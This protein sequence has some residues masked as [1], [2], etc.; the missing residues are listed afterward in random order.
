MIRGISEDILRRVYDFSDMTDEELRCKFFQKLQECIELCNNSSDILEWLK[1]EGLEKGVKDLLTIWLEDGTLE[2]LINIDKLNKKVDTETFNNAITTINEQLDNITQNGE[3]NYTN[4]GKAF[5][6]ES[7]HASWT[8]SNTHFSKEENKV[9]IFY[10]E[11]PTHNVINCKL[12]MVK[13]NSD[14]SFT[15]PVVVVD[16]NPVGISCRS[17]A[18]AILNDGTYF[19]IVSHILN[20]GDGVLSYN[21][22]IYKSSDYGTTWNVKEFLLDGQSVTTYLGDFNGVLV[23]KNGRIITH[24]SDANRGCN[25]LY[26]DDNGNTWNRATWLGNPTKH[27]EPAWCELSDGTLVAYFRSEVGDVVPYEVPAIFTKST[28]G[29][30]TWSAPVNSKS[31]IDYTQCNGNMVYCEESKSVEFLHHSRCA[32]DDGYTSLYVA[33]ANEDDV[34]NDN[35]GNQIRIGRINYCGFIK[36]L[37]VWGDG[38]YVGACRDNDGNIIGTYYNGNKNKASICYFIGKRN[39]VGYRNY[40]IDDRTG[41]KVKKE[42][43]FLYSKG[44]EYEEITGGWENGIN[45]RYGSVHKLDDKMVLHATDQY[46]RKGLTTVNKIDLTNIDYINATIYTQILNSIGEEVGASIS[47]F[48]EKNPINSTSG[49]MAFQSIT[50]KGSGVIKLDVRN[51]KGDYYVQIVANVSDSTEDGRYILFNCYDVWLEKNSDNSIDN[52]SIHVAGINDKTGF[53][54]WIYYEGKTHSSKFKHFKKVFNVG[55]GEAILD[56]DNMFF[57]LNGTGENRQGYILETAINSVGRDYLYLDFSVKGKTGICKFEIVL[58]DINNPT[59]MF[60]N[61]ILA[62]RIEENGDYKLLI[63]IGTL[64]KT[65]YLG[66]IASR[67]ANDEGTLIANVNKILLE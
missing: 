60:N 23:L 4:F 47:V 20:D 33:R 13:R 64:N 42:K 58:Y 62:K 44:N 56:E 12:M 1:N 34:K 66:L 57:S 27:T 18:S 59:D 24:M 40:D 8:Y 41:E 50:Y 10:T 52:E 5:E 16:K 26:S 29:G 36:E 45:I 19:I 21:S 43:T 38:G 7:P 37:N 22:Y 67:G 32:K 55:V 46:S 39:S 17:Q 31:I 35:F 9:V 65:F 11:K 14:G 15:K 48:T 53:R 54:D 25:I 28:D 6:T 49:R 30:L 61:R 2:N 63:P 51:L 3:Y